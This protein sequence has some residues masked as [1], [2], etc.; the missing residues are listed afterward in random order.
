MLSADFGYMFVAEFITANET[1]LFYIKWYL[2]KAKKCFTYFFFLLRR[3]RTSF[4][5]C[6]IYFHFGNRTITSD[7]RF[8]FLRRWPKCEMKS[9]DSNL[10]KNCRNTYGFQFTESKSKKKKWHFL[11]VCTSPTAPHPFAFRS[12]MQSEDELMLAGWRRTNTQFVMMN[13][14][15]PRSLILLDTCVGSSSNIG[16]IERRRRHRYISV[17]MCT[18]PFETRRKK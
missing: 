17:C 8:S 7:D 15:S 13:S 6:A 1:E 14:L 2:V 10:D 5:C 9:P 11:H 16:N 18:K 12:H 3:R 4:G